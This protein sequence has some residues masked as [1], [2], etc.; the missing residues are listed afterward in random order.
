MDI[1]DRIATVKSLIAKRQEIDA[2]LAALFRG[3]VPQRKQQKCSRCGEM[4]H[5]ADTCLQK[6]ER[7]PEQPL[8]STGSGER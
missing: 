7:L 3:Q 1:D 2:Q 8:S 5:R 6:E 4:G